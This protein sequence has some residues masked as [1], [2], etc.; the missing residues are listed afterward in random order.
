MILFDSMNAI[1]IMSVVTVTALI[2][3]GTLRM[4]VVAAYLFIRSLVT[5]PKYLLFFVSMFGILLVNKNELKLERHF[6]VSYD[7]TSTLTGWE[8]HWHVWLQNALHAPWV[9]SV[10]A[11]FYVVVFQSVMIASIAIYTMERNFK[12]YYALCAALLVNYLVAVPFYLFV[13]VGE[14]W[15]VEP[16]V[17]FLMLE[18]FPSF[19][20]HYRAL[21]GIDNC[22][23]SL[24]TSI[25]VT[26]ALLAFRSGNRR[27][28]LFAGAN[29]AIIIFSIFY[30]GIHWM[31]DM[32][33]GCVLAFV[34][35]AIGLR[36]GAW[37]DRKSPDPL[38]R[39]LKSQW[40]TK[41]YIES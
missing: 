41:G 22:F 9:T 1:M 26:M 39:R 33:A 6:Q 24:H 25:S 3:F 13:P 10:S 12:L 16:Q 32:L 2:W 37:A 27:W 36:V 35:A 17:R 18:A 30:L 20:D 23:P 4:P 11:F 40:R 38:L 31:T 19:E 7:L 29:G 15:S 5:S 34:A 8:G 14:V 28:A 21:S